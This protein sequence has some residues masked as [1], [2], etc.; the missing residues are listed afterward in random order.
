[1]DIK[2][3]DILEI[4]NSLDSKTCLELDFENNVSLLITYDNV[5]L[6]RWDTSCVT[7]EPLPSMPTFYY[8]NFEN[9]SYEQITNFDTEDLRKII[10]DT[11]EKCRYKEIN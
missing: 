6:K 1:M 5:L 9:Y 7:T 10:K 4:Q 11:I 3:I 8:D 2:D